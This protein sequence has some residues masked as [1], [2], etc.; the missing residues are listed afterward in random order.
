MNGIIKLKIIKPTASGGGTRLTKNNQESDININDIT[1]NCLLKLAIDINA[2]WITNNSF[3]LSIK[4]FIDI[5]N[6]IEIL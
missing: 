1:V 5:L 2:I 4:L 6:C 3:G